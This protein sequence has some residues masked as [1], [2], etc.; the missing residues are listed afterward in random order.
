LAKYLPDGNIA[1]VGRMDQQVKIRG[2]RVEPGEIES[3]LVQ[4]PA[5]NGAAVI[6]SDDAH[7]QTQLVAY[8]VL[9]NNHSLANNDL[10]NVLREKLPGYMIP[11]VFV[12]VPHLP[13]TANGKLDR[14]ALPAPHHDTAESKVDAVAPQDDIEV[15]LIKIWESILGRKPIGM[16]DNFFDL[17]GHS[18]LAVK[19]FAEIEKSTLRKLPL[20]VLFQAPTI[21]QLARIVRLDM[22]A[23]DHSS[24]VA[25]RPSGSKPPCFLVHGGDG[26]VL[27]FADL[28]RHMDDD[29]PLYALQSP[30]VEGEREPFTRI[31]TIAAHYIEEIRKVQPEGPYHLVGLCMGGTVVFEMS[32]QLLAQGQKVALLILLES[33]RPRR[34]TLFANFVERVQQEFDNLIVRRYQHHAQNLKTLGGRERVSYLLDKASVAKRRIISKL[35]IGTANTKLDFM[36]VYRAEVLSANRRATDSYEPKRYPGRITLFLAHDSPV[37]SPDDPRLA[38][39]ELSNGGVEIHTIPGNHMNM[40]WDP[41]AQGLAAKLTQCIDRTLALRAQS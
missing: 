25:I 40:V 3:V 17:G 35:S 28:A 6:V 14:K 39:N 24:L 30:G 38:W 12:C 26:T 10:R 2:N 8:V 32:Q 11:S 29:Q 4:H 33:P 36:P 37:K 41:Q 1:F 22:D 16:K 9:S 5:I 27:D 18:L 19:L 13:V 20:S 34:S 15:Q 21:E 7:N 23:A 31:E